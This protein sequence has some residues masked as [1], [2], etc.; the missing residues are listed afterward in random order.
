MK[1][2]PAAATA[3]SFSDQLRAMNAFLASVWRLPYTF[4]IVRRPMKPLVL[5]LAVTLLSGLCLPLVAA[6][7]EPTAIT[8]IV[9]EGQSVVVS[10]RVPA[11]VRRVTL[12]SSPKL[13]RGTWTPR[14]VKWTDGAAG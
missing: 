13:G 14:D 6:P 9:L 10:V 11:G 5:L 4:K 12:E 3:L 7:A 1:S 8:G 2:H